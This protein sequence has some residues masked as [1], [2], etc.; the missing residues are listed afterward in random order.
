MKSEPLK[1][2]LLSA[3]GI[4]LTYWTQ[5]NSPKDFG[6]VIGNAVSGSYTPGNIIYTLK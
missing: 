2:I 1:H 3:L 4:F 6:K 5:T